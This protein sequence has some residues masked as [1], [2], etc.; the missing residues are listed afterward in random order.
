MPTPAAVM[1]WLDGAAGELDQLG[2]DLEAAHISLGDAEAAWEE[3]LDIALLAIVEEYEG[4]KKRLPGED[5][6]LAMARKRMDFQ[7]YRDYIKAKRLV[8]GIE[9][10]CRKLEA[11]VSARQST[12]KGMR[13]EGALH[14][15]GFTGRG[16]P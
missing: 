9:K 5:V 8:A 7:V 13:E 14:H 1:I 6:R 10:H 16:A 15:S 12:L 2:K 11:A 4:R 3:Q